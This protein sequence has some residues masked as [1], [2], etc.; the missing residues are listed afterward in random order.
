[1]AWN[2]GLLHLIYKGKGDINDLTNYRGITVNNCISKI[3]T[4]ILN[5][6]LSPMIE[7]A[8]ILGNIPQGG[9]PGKRTTDSLFILHTIVEKSL[10]IGAVKDRDISLI[11]IDL[12][13]S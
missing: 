8:G 1:M 4:T 6:R 7:K 9:R 2:A 13:K 12:I 10:K 3:F 5:N 11:F